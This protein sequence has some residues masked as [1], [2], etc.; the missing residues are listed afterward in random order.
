[1]SE[2]LIIGIVKDA[3]FTS[4]K[5]AGPILLVSIVVGLI[6]SIFQATT[7]IQEQTL[8]FVPKLI[9]VA[10]V[11]LLT[12]SF[13]LHTIVAFTERIFELIIKIST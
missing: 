6:I 9:G 12:A 8:T 2:N 4:M 7:Q 10:A 13:M 11:G 3:L 1:M 5:M